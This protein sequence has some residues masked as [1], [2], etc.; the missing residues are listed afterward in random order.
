MA[1]LQPT[2]IRILAIGK[3]KRGWIADGVAFYR[4]RLPGLEI[5]ELKDSTPAKEAEAIR[6]ARKPAERLVLLSEEGQQLSSVGLAELLGDW[7]SERLALVIGGAD[8]HDPTLKQQA[9]G[10]LSLSALTFPHELARLMLVE[11]LYR[12]S[13]IL[14]GGPYHRS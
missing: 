10:L 2:R 12:A 6:A 7:A 5:V 9:D 14:Q 3:L 4:K 11:Q 8:G 1:L 13:T